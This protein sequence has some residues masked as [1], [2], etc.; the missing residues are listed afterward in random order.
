MVAMIPTKSPQP[1]RGRAAGERSGTRTARGSS[2]RSR[3][4]AHTQRR[5][6][7]RLAAPVI[8]AI[9]CQDIKTGHMQKIVNAAPTP[10]E[11]GR[12]RGMISAL[13]TASLEGG[14]L[15]SSGLA[16]VHWQG[17]RG[18]IAAP[19]VRS[20]EQSWFIVCCAN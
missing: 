20:R 11:G 2:A 1:A 12:V 7:E 19:A 5:L 3:K 14:C 9:V 16:K 13:V 8:D 6:C 15:A 10:G 17:S 18:S 4:H